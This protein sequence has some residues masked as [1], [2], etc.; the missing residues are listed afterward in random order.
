MVTFSQRAWRPSTS[1]A[2]TDRKGDGHSWETSNTCC[3]HKMYPALPSPISQNGAKQFVS[4][5]PSLDSPESISLFRAD[6]VCFASKVVLMRTQC[7][8]WIYYST[9]A[10]PSQGLLRLF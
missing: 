4:G 9:L 7:T 6:F 5:A 2:D 8:I 10:I 3:N 1:E